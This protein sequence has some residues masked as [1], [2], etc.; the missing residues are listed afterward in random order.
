MEPRCVSIRDW[1]LWQH[2]DLRCSA[3]LRRVE[4]QFYTVILG[5]NYSFTLRKISEERRSHL[6][7]GGSLQSRITVTS[8]TLVPPLRN[9]SY[10][11]SCEEDH[12][13]GGR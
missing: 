6:H 11:A 13:T 10:F 5:R 7:R 12:V 8:F 9:R 3:I 1:I 4:W 2:R